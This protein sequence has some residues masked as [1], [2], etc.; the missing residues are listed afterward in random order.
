MAVHGYLREIGSLLSHPYC[1]ILTNTTRT[2]LPWQNILCTGILEFMGWGSTHIKLACS[3]FGRL[4][5]I[6][7]PTHSTS[8][9]AG[10]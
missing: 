5:S 7:H 9:T 10:L 3:K 2:S 4:A 8:R 6:S 1:H